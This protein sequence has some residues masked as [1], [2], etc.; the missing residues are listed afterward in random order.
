MKA[1]SVV[2]DVSRKANAQVTLA[3]VMRAG[4][5]RREAIALLK[6]AVAT[7]R[8]LGST[9]LAAKTADELGLMLKDTGARTRAAEHVK[10][11]SRAKAATSPI[12]SPEHA[13]EGLPLS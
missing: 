4:G 7:L 1:A 8:R 10:R 9:D 5:R 2:S 3:R 13:I 6:A 11:A 12:R